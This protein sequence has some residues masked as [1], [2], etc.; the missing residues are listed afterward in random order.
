VGYVGFRAEQ[1]IPAGTKWFVWG[2]EP[3][4]VTE[5]NPLKNLRFITVLNLGA[6]ATEDVVPSF[7]GAY[8]AVQGDWHPPFNPEV[9]PQ[10]WD[11]ARQIWFRLHHYVD[12]QLSPGRILS[13]VI[14]QEL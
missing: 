2:T 14:A 1:D 13:G 10:A 3:V 7:G 11:P 4:L 9:N 8:Q 6:M 12:G 5:A